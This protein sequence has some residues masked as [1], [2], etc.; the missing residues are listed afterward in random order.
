MRSLSGRARRLLPAWC[1]V[2][3]FFTTQAAAQDEPDFS[4]HWI[5]VSPSDTPPTAARAMA[6]QMAY[7]RESVRGNPIT[8][9]LV[10]LT[11]ERTFD[12]EVGSQR[13]TIGTTG[14]WVGGV[15]GNAFADGS[16]LVAQTRFSTRW[17]G[18]KLVIELSSSGSALNVVTDS[19]R[20]EVWTID[21]QGALSIAVT[22]RSARSESTTTL[23]YRRREP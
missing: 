19:F 8:P 20:R 3:P 9:P 7:T 17:N 11:I 2:V 23:V 22:D 4:G 15:S 6:V 18:D 5:L 21:E 13:L 1:L 12:A 14:G 16:P 10:T